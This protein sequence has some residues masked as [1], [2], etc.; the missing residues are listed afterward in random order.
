MPV[1]D[2]MDEMDRDPDDMEDIEDIINKSETYL[3]TVIDNEMPVD[4]KAEVFLAN[5][6]DLDELY[7]SGN[8]AGNL[9]EIN[10]EEEKTHR[11]ELGETIEDIDKKL[12]EGDLYMGVKVVMGD[13]AEE[14]GQKHTFSSEQKIDIK[15][16][17][18]VG[19]KVNQ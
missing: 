4:I 1:N 14:D 11:F 2:L 17:L 9:L 3:E 6:E 16:H 13:F 15:S 8:S 19:I 5:T 7:S 12:E 18:G 10:S